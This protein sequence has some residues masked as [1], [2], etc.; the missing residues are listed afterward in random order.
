[1]EIKV[2]ALNLTDELRYAYFEYPE[3]EFGDGRSRL[4][5]ALYSGTTIMVGLRGSF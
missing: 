4:D 5:N 3:G 2:D 1:M